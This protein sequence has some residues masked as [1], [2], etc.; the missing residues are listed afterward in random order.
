ME[1]PKTEKREKENGRENKTTERKK[2]G[3]KGIESDRQI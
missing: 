3:Q 2:E 1:Q